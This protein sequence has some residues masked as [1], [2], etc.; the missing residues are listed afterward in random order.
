MA[1][2]TI[3]VKKTANSWQY[4][5]DADTSWYDFSTSSTSP[6]ALLFETLTT[7]DFNAVNNGGGCSDVKCVSK[8]A[9]ITSGT[10]Y[11]IQVKCGADGTPT[12]GYFS[13][14]TVGRDR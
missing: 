11:T 9:S 3:S 10:T 2:S 8:P 12:T 6:Q 1:N 14:G 13:A 7:L 5:G 4:Q